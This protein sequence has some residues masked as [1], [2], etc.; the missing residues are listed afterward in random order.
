MTRELAAVMLALAGIREG[1]VILDL[2]GDPLLA[3]A[4]TA[5]TGPAGRLVRPGEVGP[6]PAFVL[7]TQS[8]DALPSRLP[9]GTRVVLA[10]QGAGSAREVLSRAGLVPRHVEPI[11]TPEGTVEVA[12]ATAAGP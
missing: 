10:A 7:A 5:A 4:A 11:A 6:P 12:A 9:G 8:L 2:A 3:R 1:S